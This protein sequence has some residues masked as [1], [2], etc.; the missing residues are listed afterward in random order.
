M[1]NH[2]SAVHKI[3]GIGICFIV[4]L[5]GCS[6]RNSSALHQYYTENY[7]ASSPIIKQK[8]EKV[9]KS[10]ED[11]TSMSKQATTKDKFTPELVKKDIKKNNELPDIKQFEEKLFKSETLAKGQLQPPR[12]LNLAAEKDSQEEYGAATMIES[13][14]FRLV[15]DA[16][17]RR[18][19]TE[20]VRL[21]NFFL[22]SFPHSSRKAYLDEKLKSFFYSEDLEVAKLKDALVEITYPVARTLDELSQYFSKLNSNGLSAVQIEVVQLLGTPVY[23]FANPQSNQGYYFSIDEGKVVDKLLSKITG[24]AHEAGLKVMVSFPLRNHPQ[25]SSFPK[26]IMDESWNAY[27]NRTVP[28]G[29]LDLLNP[30][31]KNLLQSLL[32]SLI[33]SNI[34][35]VIFKDDFTYEAYEGFSKKALDRYKIE[36]GRTVVFNR[37]FR[38]VKQ[39]KSDQIEMLIGEDFDDVA[40]WRTQEIK[41]LLW[42][43]IATIKDTKKEIIVGFELTPEMILDSKLSMKW[44]S[45]GLHYIKDLNA[46]FFI[47]KWRKH[48]STV[49]SDPA[50]YKK[51][52]L[53][54]RGALSSKKELLIKVPLSDDTRNVI[55]LNRRI[56]QNAEL[57][58]EMSMSKIAIGPVS[59]IDNN[60]LLNQ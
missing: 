17:N 46:D 26:Y 54:L 9:E 47:L 19:Q 45:T 58:G 52:A 59:R 48:K 16:Y 6:N 13:K 40:L 1:R 8:V 21:Y 41:Q 37:M 22:E 31:S 42:D 10:K 29:K 30:H 49:E 57:L 53:L 33:S 4:F 11:P 3:L 35:G 43:L 28:N 39:P 60:V 51:A 34:D 36:T 55:K 5:S 25:L 2:L 15:E 38:P 24:I 14:L 12:D 23:L 7:P 32:K 20:F 56:N 18:D 27:E 50:D 44:Y